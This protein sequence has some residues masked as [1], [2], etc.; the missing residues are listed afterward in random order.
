[1]N[2]A[3][4]CNGASAGGAVLVEKLVRVSISY[5]QG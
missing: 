2:H 5:L 4:G 1:M 3:C